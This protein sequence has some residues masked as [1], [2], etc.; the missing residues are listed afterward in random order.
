MTRTPQGSTRAQRAPPQDTTVPEGGHLRTQ[1]DTWL[2]ALRMST[3]PAVAGNTPVRSASHQWNTP[4]WNA[5]F[6]PP[7]RPVIQSFWTTAAMASTK[8]V[9]ARSVEM[10][11]AAET[12]R[13]PTHTRSAQLSCAD[14]CKRRNTTQLCTQR[15]PRHARGVTQRRSEAVAGATI[16]LTSV[17]GLAAP[18][19]TRRDA[20]NGS[21]RRMPE[22]CRAQTHTQTRAARAAAATRRRR[23]VGHLGHRWFFSVEGWSRFR[24]SGEMRGRSSSFR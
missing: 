5:G 22:P 12:S 6:C 17:S 15:R 18:H 3:G 14:H 23:T 2:S 9:S 8:P 11:R 13:W 16:R 20:G 19:A 21:H 4:L 1:H 10:W 24:A 7:T